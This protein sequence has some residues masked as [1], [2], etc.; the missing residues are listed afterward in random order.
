MGLREPNAG[1]IPLL[2]L[3]DFKVH[4]MGVVIQAIQALGMEVVFIPLGCT[5]MAQPVNTGYSKPLK[6][7]TCD[8]YHEWIFAQDLDML[9]PCPTCHQVAKCIVAAECKIEDTMVCNAWRKTGFSFFPNKA[10]V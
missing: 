8:Q 10:R 9:I 6:V 1:I 3:D 7:K 5:R 4:K 2:L